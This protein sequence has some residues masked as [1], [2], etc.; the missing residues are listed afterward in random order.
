[1]Q[2]RR[3]LIEDI[4]NPPTAFLLAQLR[5][6]LDPLRLPARKRVRRLLNTVLTTYCVFATISI[7]RVRHWLSR[8]WKGQREL[9]MPLVAYTSNVEKELI[10]E[11]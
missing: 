1:M 5:R 2:S 7:F 3:R 10:W 4:Q 9:K 8:T 11:N 6:Q